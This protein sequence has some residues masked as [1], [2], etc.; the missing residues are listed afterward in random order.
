MIGTENAIYKA[1]DEPDWVALRVEDHQRQGSTP[2]LRIWGK[3]PPILV[4]N[5]G[6]AASSTVI[7]PAMHEEFCLPYD[8]LQHEALHR[9]GNARRLSSLR[10]TDASFG[11]R[12]A[13]RGGRA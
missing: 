9:P 2:P 4:E 5:G 13:K 1:M 7:S 3:F 10:R 11:T 6:G 8:K 12:Q